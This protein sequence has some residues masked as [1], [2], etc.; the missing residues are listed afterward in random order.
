MTVTPVNY[1]KQDASPEAITRD[2]DYALQIADFYISKLPGGA[3]SLIYKHVLELGPGISLGTAVLLSCHGARVTVADRYLSPFDPDYHDPFF[4]ALLARLAVER[5]HL[6]PDPILACLD[7]QVFVEQGV[8]GLHLGIEDLLEVD[9]DSFDIVVSNAVFEHVENVPVA[10]ENLARITRPG[11]FGIHQVDFRDHRDFSRPLEYMTLSSKKFQK[12]FSDVHGECGNRWRPSAMGVEIDKAGFDILEYDDNMQAD[13]AYLDDVLP[14]VDSHFS[15]LDREML[16]S[17]SGCFV[18]RLRVFANTEYPQETDSPQTLAHSRCRYA[19][20][21]PSVVGKAV[22]DVGCG[23]GIGTRQMLSQGAAHVVGIDVR[24][25]ALEVAVRSDPRGDAN[26][27]LLHNLNQP[28][29]LPDDS[30]DVVVAL[31]VLEHVTNQ[32]ELLAE[33]R[34]VL[35]PDGVAFVSV[36]NKAFED[37][38]SDMAGEPNPYHIHVP[39]LEEYVGLLSDFEWVEFFGQLDVVSSLVLPLDGNESQVAVGKLEVQAGASI[40]DRGTVTIIARCQSER[41]AQEPELKPV[42]YAY[43]NYQDTFG[44][45]LARNR[46]LALE[47][48]SYLHNHF[49]AANKLRWQ[50]LQE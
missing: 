15:G 13:E 8:T 18:S 24:P 16:R 27:Y 12:L 28:L 37:F 25:E 14:R 44:G 26:A 31:E 43:G 9:D 1:R 50:E 2:V 35:R 30:F 19:F 46:S 45:V 32:A 38:W 48:E 4:R 20:V 21:G 7:A 10:W 49:T 34:R 22:L 17:I 23:A 6:S 41:P 33:M 29:P 36:P 47:A 42:A 40:S 39:D 3:S 11:G 5:S